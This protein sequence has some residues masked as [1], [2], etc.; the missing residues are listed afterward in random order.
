MGFFKWLENGEIIIN[1]GRKYPG[2]NI[3]DVAREDPK[4]LHWAW[5]ERGIGLPSDLFSAIEDVMRTNGVP[6][7][8]P[9]R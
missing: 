8:R 5:K 6:F 7:K 3:V 9:K 4:F 1:G 2:R